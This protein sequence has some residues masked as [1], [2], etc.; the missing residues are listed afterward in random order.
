MRVSE[1]F[2]N[3]TPAEQERLA[4]LLEEMGEAVQVIGKILRHGWTPT[5]Y[6][7]QPPRPYDNRADLERELGD[8]RAAMIRLCSADDLSKSVIHAR[9]NAKLASN[10]RMHHQ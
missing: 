5:D 8:V 4:V 7:A 1:H 2:S 3:L 6:A 10:I 9:A